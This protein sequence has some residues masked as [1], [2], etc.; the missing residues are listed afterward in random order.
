MKK[1]M[2]F[3]LVV[4]FL[5]VITM[6][7]VSHAV[8]SFA[9]QVQK[10]CTACHTMWPNLNQAGRQFKVKA[11]TDAS[12]KWDMIN[13]DG[14][15]LATTFPVSARV[16]YFPEVRE[17]ND[18]TGFHQ[19]STQFDQVAL[20]IASRVYDYAGVFASAEW[21]PDSNTFGLPTAKVAFQYPL[22]KGNTIGVVGFKGLASAADPFNAVGGRDRSLAWGDESEPLILTRGWTFSFSDEGNVGTVVHGYFLGNRLYAAVGAMRGGKSE[23]VSGGALLNAEPGVAVADTDPY[24]RFWRLAWDQKL[25]NGA[26]T[27]GVVGYDGTQRILDGTTF[28]PS[29]DTKV[30]RSYVD[31]SLEQNF[32]EDH[33]FELQALVGNGEEK[34]IFGGDEQ[35]KFSGSY[36]EG[37]YFY[38]RTIGFVV[39]LNTIKFKDVDAADVTGHED[40]I[41][42]TLVS[43]NYL[44]WLNTKLALQY[45]TTKTK[46][47]DPDVEPDQT[48]KISRIV[49][50]VAF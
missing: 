44:P 12:E 8:P 28:L 9:R 25:P 33:L 2:L 37:S 34:N 4:V 23:D 31:L 45:V 42:S 16:L 14:L 50:D 10:P 29:F 47:V 18:T 1:N 43:L 3:G 17:D 5:A 11:Y 48:N 32:G 15:N 49:F 19:S 41:D 22:G 13:K 21:S 36:I 30:K 38:D 7:Y 40:T 6:P 26:V 27:I 39:A 35:R 24:D 46:F 20:F